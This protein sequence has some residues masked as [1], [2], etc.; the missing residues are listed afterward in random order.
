MKTGKGIGKRIG[1]EKTGEDKKITDCLFFPLY[2]YLPFP[3]LYVN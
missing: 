3:F 1:R 2:L